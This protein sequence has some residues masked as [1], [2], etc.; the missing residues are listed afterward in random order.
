MYD[1]IRITKGWFLSEPKKLGP[2][3]R[4][5]MNRLM[6]SLPF[7]VKK[8]ACQAKTQSMDQLVELVEGHQ[9]AQGV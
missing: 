9:V 6:R 1:F 8:L 5:V 2:I 7:E 3:E 4:V